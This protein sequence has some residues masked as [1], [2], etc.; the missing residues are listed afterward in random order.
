M[1]LQYDEIK[2]EEF[3][4]IPDEYY[5]GQSRY[6]AES[7]EGNQIYVYVTIKFWEQ[8]EPFKQFEARKY[9]IRYDHIWG[10]P[11]DIICTLCECAL[12]PNEKD[13]VR[14]IADAYWKECHDEFVREQIESGESTAEEMAAV[15][16]DSTHWVD[17]M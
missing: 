14:E 7:W 15:F 9:E 1:S 17:E 5:Y 10:S 13:V 11:D 2:K 4:M 12:C 16:C 3:D 6:V 8:K